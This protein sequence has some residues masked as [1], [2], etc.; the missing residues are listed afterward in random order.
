[1]GT[2]AAGNKV[3]I[4]TICGGAVPEN[5]PLSEFAKSLHSIWR[6]SGDTPKKRAM[7]DEIACSRLGASSQHLP[8]PDCIYRIDPKTGQPFVKAEE[9]LYKPYSQIEL[10]ELTNLFSTIE[11][12]KGT[13]VAV[14][15]GIG[16]HRD[17]A[18]TRAVGEHF[19]GPV[20]HYLDYPYVVQKSIR[21]KELM[22]EKSARLN[23]TLTSG[24]LKAWKDA[25]ACY[26]SQL[27]VFWKNIN[28]MELAMDAYI[29]IIIGQ[30]SGT[31]LWK[32]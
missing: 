10:S 8:W 23:Q 6:T 24:G 22:P 32:F 26:E 18:L 3:E 1:M 27:P 20:W 2:G 21:F 19:F 30:N 14:P 17:H 28:A 9:D 15:F 5:L 31:Q 25:I 13:Q 29:K 4:W 16:S 7:E 12:P 11:L